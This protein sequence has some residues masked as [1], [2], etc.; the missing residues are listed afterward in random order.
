MG[1]IGKIF[2]KDEK[3]EQEVVNKT[4]DEVKVENQVEPK[5]EKEIVQEQKVETDVVKKDKNNEP[6]RKAE[7]VISQKVSKRQDINAY[8]V[9]DH[10]L[11][12]EKATD[13][14]A[15]NKYIFVVPLSANKSEIVKAVTNIYGVK[16]IKIN[17]IKKDGKRVRYGKVSG[18]RKSFKK[19]IVTFKD[20][21]K[22]EVH[23]G[24]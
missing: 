10:P 16:P 20:G 13:L 2:K 11:I 18:T 24:V 17:I 4:T 21:D 3:E 12:T 15:L 7:V 19:A 14:T 1:I 23:E 8:R 22:I 5:Q 6:V 9:I